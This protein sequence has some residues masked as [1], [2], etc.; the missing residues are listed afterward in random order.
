LEL[1][2]PGFRAALLSL[3]LPKEQLHQEP[4]VLAAHGA[5]DTAQSQCEVWREIIGA[6]GAILCIAGTPIGPGESNG[7]FFKNHLELE[8]EMLAAVAALRTELGEHIDDRDGVYVSYS[9]GGAMGSLML[10]A[11]GELFSRLVLVEG[12]A[13]DWTLKRGQQFASTG[14]RRILFACGTAGCNRGA[15]RS[16]QVLASSGLTVRHLDVP[17]GGHA[18]WGTVAESVAQ[19]WPWVIEDDPRWQ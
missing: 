15:R 10:P 13:W 2:V 9:Q 8:K 11:H 4:L 19:L 14:G 17:G 7:Y 18:Y 12:G 1:Q 3:P 16:V 5:G 6:C